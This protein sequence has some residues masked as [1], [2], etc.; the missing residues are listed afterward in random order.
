MN[1]PD[2]MERDR[3]SLAPEPGTQ[4]RPVLV[5]DDHEDI[6]SSIKDMLETFG[7]AVATAANGKEALDYLKQGPLP[8]LILLDLTMPLMN[9]WDFRKRQRNDPL[10]AHIPTVVMSGTERDQ[11]GSE[12]EV[13]DYMQKPIDPELILEVVETYY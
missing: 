4:P 1:R 3:P 10:L 6:R 2:V 7:Y 8:C 11:I 12:L 5:V 13:D 9:G